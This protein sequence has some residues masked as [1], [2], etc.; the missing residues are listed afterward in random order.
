MSIL[1]KWY[2]VELH[3]KDHLLGIQN[4]YVMGAAN[5]LPICIVD[6][7]TVQVRNNPPYQFQVIVNNNK[8]DVYP[9]RGPTISTT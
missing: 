2:P 1:T 7:I 4:N 5:F 9:D 8:A 6:H 3:P